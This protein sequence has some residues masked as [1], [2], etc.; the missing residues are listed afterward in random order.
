M[1]AERSGGSFREDL[2]SRG[3]ELV[4]YLSEDK[5]GSLFLT[6]WLDHTD[7]IGCGEK[8]PQPMRSS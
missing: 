4:I 3:P 1:H 5:D 2:G 8:D 6:L 7:E